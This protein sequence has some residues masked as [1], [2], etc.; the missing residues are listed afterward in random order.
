MRRLLLITSC[1]LLAVPATASATS[2]SVTRAANY[3]VRSQS[4]KGCLGDRE[5]TGWG[6]IALR[7]AGKRAA[8]RRA[9]VCF[10]QTAGPLTTAT[11]R[12]LGIMAAVAG[13]IS[14]RHV[15][16]RDLVR[17]L[18]RSRRGGYYR[19]SSTNGAIFGVLA[20]RAAGRPVPRAV[21]RQI[22]R[23]Q[24]SGGGF[25][26]FP[27]G[28]QADMTAAGIQALKAAGL[29]CSSRPVRRALVALE[30][31]RVGGGYVLGIGQRP[32][33]QSTAWAVQARVACNRPVTSSLR[34]LKA[35][36]GADG[37]VRYG[38]VEVGRIWVTGQV[39]PALARRWWPI[40]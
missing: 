7:A 30:R 22:L 19:G 24:S 26:Y 11:D 2:A 40:R 1:L 28:A 20:L 29:S 6:A 17:A 13:G 14:P 16:G 38:P 27:E 3:L 23:D 25:D 8:A 31:F 18:E 35:R 4:A 32:N 36:Q 12:E 15:G 5:G 33:A 21:V 34:W 10:S 9:A 37:S 39:I